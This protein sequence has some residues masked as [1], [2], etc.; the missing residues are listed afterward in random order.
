MKT[1]PQSS[2]ALAESVASCASRPEQACSQSRHP[3]A[4]A[5]VFDD[6]TL[7]QTDALMLAQQSLIEPIELDRYAILF[8]L[9]IAALMGGLMGWERGRADKP[10]G[11][12]TMLLISAGA[13]A[14]ALLGEQII[15]A[16]SRTDIIR[17]DPT[18]VLSY[19]ISGVGFLGAG[20]ILHSK[21]T[22]KGITTAASIWVAAAVG[23]ACGVGQYLIGFLLFSIAFITLWAPW[24]RD[25][26]NGTIDEELNGSVEED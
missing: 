13:A 26:A 6:N 2:R 22:V 5:R 17:V 24:V 8:R 19:I 7:M 10:V 12:R 3:L 15:A 11:I 4:S 1:G 20:A 23:A 25:L 16:S 9:I 21:R 18:R 14:F